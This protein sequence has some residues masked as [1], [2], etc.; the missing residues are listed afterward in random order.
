VAAHLLLPLFL[1]RVRLRVR[2]KQN[3]WMT[4]KKT[5]TSPTRNQMH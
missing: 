5:K 4:R 3:Y 2:Q 1:V